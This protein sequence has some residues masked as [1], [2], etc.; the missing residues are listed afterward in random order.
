MGKFFGDLALGLQADAFAHSLRKGS[1]F[2]AGAELIVPIKNK[3]G[4]GGESTVFETYAAHGQRL[5]DSG[6]VQLHRA[7][8]L[9]AHPDQL[10]LARR[11][12]GR[13]SARRSAPTVDT[14]VAG[15]RWWSSSQDQ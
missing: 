9:S 2:S 14:A 10:P 12:S 13:Q 1:I 5:P 15:R 8:S 4:T 11:I 3:V 6:F 7:S